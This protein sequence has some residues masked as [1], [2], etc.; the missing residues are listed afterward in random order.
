MRD[1]GPVTQ[2]E[3]EFDDQEII[4]S[5]TGPAGWISFVNRAFVRISGYD[6]ADL[7]RATAV[8]PYVMQ[9]NAA[10]LWRLAG[11]TPPQTGQVWLV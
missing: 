8:W 4:V 7:L 9:R 3:I 1:N 5:G 11:S 10:C 2:R 6:E